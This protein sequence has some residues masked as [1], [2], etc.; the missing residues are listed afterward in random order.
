MLIDRSFSEVK[1]DKTIA[2]MLNLVTK[3]SV[4]IKRKETE[5]FIAHNLMDS[6]TRDVKHSTLNF[7]WNGKTVVGLSFSLSLSCYCFDLTLLIKASK[8]KGPKRLH[9]HRKGKTVWFWPI[10]L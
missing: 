2:A 10:K 5:N 3:S 4:Q 6:E 1:C 7:G 9:I 8:Y